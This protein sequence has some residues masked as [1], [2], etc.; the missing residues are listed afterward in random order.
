MWIYVIYYHDP[1]ALSIRAVRS[2]SSSYYSLESTSRSLR[3][4]YFRSEVNVLMG[5]VMDVGLG[6]GLGLEC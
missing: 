1:I 4:F 6:L 2:S 3:V 5:W